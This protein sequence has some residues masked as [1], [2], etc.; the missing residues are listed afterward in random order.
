M[1]AAWG[2]RQSAQLPSLAEL[3][4][5][6]GAG[7]RQAWAAALDAPAAGD[8]AECLLRLEVAAEV[9][10]PAP[11]TDQR[12]ALQLLLLTRRNDPAPAQTW[13]QDVAR[14]LAT[15]WSAAHAPRLQA[16]LKAL[17]KA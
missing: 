5:R 3:R 15:P 10:T 9:P 11:W 7:V 17:L 14:L 12:R 13:A 4:G 8:G 1:L 6:V 2:Q 16:V